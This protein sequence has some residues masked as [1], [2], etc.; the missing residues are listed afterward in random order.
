MDFKDKKIL[1]TGAASGIGK[2][3]LR[4]AC[5]KGASIVFAWDRDERGLQQLLLEFPEFTSQLATQ[6][7]DLNQPEEIRLR[8]QELLVNHP[9][10][11]ILINN[12][13]IVVGKTFEE[14]SWQDIQRSMQINSLALMQLTH[15]FL[16]GMMAQNS[17]VICNIAS[18]AG[19]VA[20]PKMSVYAASKWAVIG[21]SDSLR[22]ELKQIQKNIQVCTVMPYYISTG[23]FEGVKSPLIPI[24]KPEVAAN[25]IIR[26]IERGSAM[27][28][29]PLP[30][31]FI[32]LAQGIMPLGVYDW[33]MQ[34]VF[35]IY[36]SMDEFKGRG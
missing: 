15:C 27:V 36:N 35:K 28:A 16:P 5:E 23:M 3:M 33:I 1:I 18:L 32:R 34:H 6:I 20:N 12:A 17:G 4:K 2:I 8:A 7:I 22:L 9:A 19:L 21:W 29:M 11:D 14:H 13:G 10:I 31:W 25:K 24:V 26:G 30:F